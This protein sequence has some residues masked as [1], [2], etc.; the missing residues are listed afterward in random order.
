LSTSIPDFAVHFDSE[1]FE[2]LDQLALLACQ[3]YNLG[4]AGDWFGDFRGGLYGFY[5]RLYG[6]QRHYSE[7]HVWL[8]PH[9]R[10]PDETEYHLAS[11]LFQMDSALECLTFALNA[12]GWAAMPSGFWDVTDGEAL[13]RIGPLDILGDPA[14]KRPRKP[15]PGYTA[16]FPAFQ[17]F[18][19]SQ[20]R[21]ISQI[22]DL[23]DVSKHRQTIYI[24]SKRRL[25]TPAGFYE[26]LGIPEESSNREDSS[27]RTLLC[28]EA[29]IILK[30]D[31]KSSSLQRSARPVGRRDLLE[32]LV[33]SFADFINSSGAAAL[34]DA[35]VQVPL[36][37]S[38]FRSGTTPEVRKMSG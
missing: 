10:T 7:V 3:D 38:R 1:P 2:S 5:A 12:L 20:A 30:P 33:P 23:H 32:A 35:Q 6:V 8:P 28:P 25:D 29:E 22:R 9:V 34:A 14:R 4:G 27:L 36:K 31:P 21:L 16:I 11:I 26:S 15:K 13:R 24:G 17:A 37:E 18:W 19:Q